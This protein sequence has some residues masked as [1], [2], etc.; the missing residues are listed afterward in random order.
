MNDLMKKID[1]AE[2]AREVVKEIS[3]AI[4]ES[5]E[6]SAEL[7]SLVCGYLAEGVDFGIEKRM[8]D[9]SDRMGVNVFSLHLT[10]L[11]ECALRAKK[12]YDERGIDESVYYDT[13]CDL[14]YKVKECKKMYG[15]CGVSSFSWY[16]GIMLVNTFK[17]GRLEYAV[18]RLEYDE[19]KNYAKRG[20]RVYNCHIP[21]CGPLTYELVID[22]LERAYKFF[23]CKDY[24]IVHC[25]S[26]M[27]YPPVYR[28]VF[29]E[30]SNLKMFYELFDIVGETPV[31]SNAANFWRIF[32]KPDT[33]PLDELPTDTTLQRSFIK[34]FKEGKFM[35]TGK[36]IIVFD[37]KRIVNK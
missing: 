24:L 23:G 7:D 21:S 3:L 28:E 31:T 35:G 11:L 10:F 32:Y 13:M 25:S 16:H 26:W 18:G 15:V 1:L 6:L 8:R 22:S 29:P 34:Y 36:G 9:M 20:D 37:G 5:P 19:Y 17:L 14:S 2:D 27:L 4:S 33:T 12:V 30:G